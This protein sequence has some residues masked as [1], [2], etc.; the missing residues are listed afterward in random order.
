MAKTKSSSRRGQARAVLDLERYVPA[1]L[2]FLANKLT[3]GASAILRRHFGV[4]TTEWRTMAMLAV[5]PWIAAG[6][7]CKVIGFDKAAVSRTLAL[8]QDKGLIRARSHQS[9]GRSLVYALTEKGWRLHDRIL[10]ISL[11]REQRLLED[12]SG[13]EREVLIALLNRLHRRIPAMNA[14]IDIPRER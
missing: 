9:D 8:L 4:G 13:G 6:R 1:L 10:K 11:E 14:P 5:E 12:L 2:V 3:S 7:V